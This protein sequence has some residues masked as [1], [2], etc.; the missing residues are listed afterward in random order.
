MRS[1][2]G[3]DYRLEVKIIQKF[4]NKKIQKK[5]QFFFQKNHKISF[6]SGWCYQPELKLDLQAAA[7]WRAFSPGSRTG[8]KGP[9]EPALKAL[10]LLVSFLKTTS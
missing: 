8:T 5:I 3:G 9:Y 10:F 4:E 6:S 2:E 1:D 7:T